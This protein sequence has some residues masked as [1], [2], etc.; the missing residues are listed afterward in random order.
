[1]THTL[2]QMNR[3]LVGAYTLGLL[4]REKNY[5]AI[6]IEECVLCKM[7]SLIYWLVIRKYSSSPWFPLLAAAE[8]RVNRTR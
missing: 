3:I 7:S 2:I 8:T 1:M 5:V 6:A 4:H